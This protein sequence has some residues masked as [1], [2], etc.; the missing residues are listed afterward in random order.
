[1][2]HIRSIVVGVDFSPASASAIRQSLRM[3][4][5]TQAPIKAVHVLEGLVRADLSGPMLI[6]LQDLYDQLER[7]AQEKWKH[8]LAAIPEAAG[9]PLTVELAGVVAQL[10]RH[11]QEHAGT[12]LVLG[13][14][15]GKG[16]RASSAA[17]GCVRRSTADVLLVRQSDS[18]PFKTIVACVDFSATSQRA[19][20]HAVR[21]A[22]RDNASL[23]IIHA[24][25]APWKRLT[26]S[27]PGVPADIDAR[28]G[29]MMVDRLRE[30]CAPFSHEL[31]YVATQFKV[32]EHD[33]HGH[34]ISV[35][36][37]QILADLVVLG[38][39]G[40]ANLRD[41]FLGST[42]ERVIASATC[43]VLVVGPS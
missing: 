5:W 21:I 41:M 7:E 34:G 3:A 10:S 19:L 29:Q 2:N 31:G 8:F 12:L 6:T 23:F 26:L 22:A 40:E 16:K 20:E 32:L 37:E 27:R 1:M 43:S 14:A 4:A 11:S 35:F 30:F 18:G 13:I 15:G 36:T 33:T 24:Y 42:A 28:F 17:T 25:T 39:R 38:K 9:M